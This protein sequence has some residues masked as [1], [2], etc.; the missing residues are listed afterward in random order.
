MLIAFASPRAPEQERDVLTTSADSLQPLRPHPPLASSPPKKRVVFAPDD[1]TGCPPPPPPHGRSV[2]DPKIPIGPPSQSAPLPSRGFLLTRLSDAGPAPSPNAP[3]KGRRPKPFS[4]ADI[5]GCGL[6]RL[7]WAESA[8]PRLA[9]GRTGVHSIAGVPLRARNSPKRK[10]RPRIEA[11]FARI[12]T[13]H[14]SGSPALRRPSN[15]TGRFGARAISHF[16]VSWGLR[17]WASARSN[18]PSSLLPS[19]A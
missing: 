3:A 13:A 11:A 15:K 12:A 16:T 8:P 4:R 9:S 14:S 7:N 18:F 10:T 19:S 17:R 6:G 1:N 5:V 2:R